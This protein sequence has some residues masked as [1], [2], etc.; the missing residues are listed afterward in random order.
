MLND[1]NELAITQF[2]EY[3][4]SIKKSVKPAS[5]EALRL[6]LSRIG[7][8]QQQQACVDRSIANG[9]IGIF[10]PDTSTVKRAFQ[11]V[12]TKTP[13]QVEFDVSQFAAQNERAGTHWDTSTDPLGKLLLCEALLARYSVTGQCGDT[14]KMDSLREVTAKHIRA[15]EPSEVL[16]NPHINGLVRFL[17]GERGIR[18]LQASCV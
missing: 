6:K 3:R 13:K 14:E 8:N 16:G 11:P 12:T 10:P 15:A 7:D 4:K 18:R 17:F 2:I 1:I 9:W 5:L